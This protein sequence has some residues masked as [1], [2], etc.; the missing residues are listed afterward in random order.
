MRPLLGVVVVVGG[1][2]S[3]SPLHSILRG[4]AATK[5]ERVAGGG[6]ASRHWRRAKM[7][8]AHTSGGKGRAAARSRE[9]DGRSRGPGGDVVQF[10]RRPESPRVGMSPQYQ[11]ASKPAPLLHTTLPL[12]RLRSSAQADGAG[13]SSSGSCYTSSAEEGGT[14][15]DEELSIRVNDLVPPVTRRAEYEM[16]WEEKPAFDEGFEVINWGV[17]A[18]TRTK[19]SAPR[20]KLSGTERARASGAPLL[21]SRL[22]AVP[23]RGRDACHSRATKCRHAGLKTPKRKPHSTV[24][25]LQVV[26]FCRECTTRSLVVAPQQ[27]LGARNCF[28]CK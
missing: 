3:L 12:P 18:H 17:S 8:L 15:D 24:R 26:S 23:H 7:G 14:D 19:L 16:E 4:A 13:S 21:D 10:E 5:P 25:L 20:A 1:S 22:P 27:K 9:R 28:Y 6:A 2:P 11:A